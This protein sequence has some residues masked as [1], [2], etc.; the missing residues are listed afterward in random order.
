MEDP[1]YAYLHYDLL[2]IVALTTIIL[3]AKMVAPC[4]LN[5]YI[6]IS[7]H[8]PCANKK[9]HNYQLQD[10]KKIRCFFIHIYTH[11]TQQQN[12]FHGNS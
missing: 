9:N 2:D 3:K 12:T 1:R 4:G 11:K 7:N 10:E 6:F 5:L 8:G